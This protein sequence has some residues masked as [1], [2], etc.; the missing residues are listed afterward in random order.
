MKVDKS[1]YTKEQ[2]RRIRDK[3]RLSKHQQKLDT[4]PAFVLGNGVSRQPINLELLKTKGTI[5]GCNALYREFSPDYL[6]AV[7]PRMVKEIN[8]AGYQ[9][10]NKVYTNQNIIYKSYKNFKYFEPNRGWSSGPSAL[11]LASLNNHKTIY[12]LGFDYKGI[13]GKN[14]VNNIYADTPNYKRSHEA[15]TF[16]GNWL[17]QTQTV[18][19]EN[20]NIQ[21]YRVIAEDNYQPKELNTFVNFTTILIDK[22]QSTFQ[23][24]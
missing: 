22:F 21:F 8:N 16:H 17:R 2:W 14:L 18:L 13:A 19:R 11:W 1:L 12:M 15:A 10:K 9:L 5:Y 3:R 6:V 4:Q 24:I 23:I 7:D 20:K